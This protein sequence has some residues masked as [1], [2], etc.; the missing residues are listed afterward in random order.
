M[1]YFYDTEF[2]EGAQKRRIDNLELPKMFNT[3]NTIDLISIGI[4]S[5]DGREYYA[6]SKDF[7]L[8]EAWYRYDLKVEEAYGDMRNRFPNVIAKKVYWIRENVLKPIFEDLV[9][10]WAQEEEKVNQLGATSGYNPPIKFSYKNMKKLVRK[11]GKTNKQISKEIY[12]F[13]NPDLGYHVT[14]YNNSEL[15]EGGRLHEHFE[16]HNVGSDGIHY[17]AQPK[18]YSYYGAY[19]HVAF[20]WLFG[21]MIDLPMGFPMYSID[22]KQELDNKYMY[23]ENK[24]ENLTRKQVWNQDVKQL[25]GY[26]KQTNE[27]NALADAQWNKKLYEFL[28]EL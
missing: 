23:Q 7:N 2:L 10:R 21:K 19:D 18:F 27:H 20:C 9:N 16:K 8:K 24:Y 17:Y 14:G 1:K 13:V 12:D 6:I 28:K 3:K 25:E 5:E 26:P 15:K 22:L 4:V 11:Y